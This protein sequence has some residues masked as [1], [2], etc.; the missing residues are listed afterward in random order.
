MTRDS[1][2][3]ICKRVAPKYGYDP[4]LILAQVE[5]ESSYK[6]DALRLEQGFLVKYIAGMPIAAT[7]KALLST[8]FGLGQL[9]GQSLNELGFFPALDSVS[10]V[11]RLEVYLGTPEMQ[12]ETQCQWLQKKQ[13][14][15]TSHTMDDALRRYNGSADYPPLVYAR[16]NNLKGLYGNNLAEAGR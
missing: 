2:Y 14:Q 6:E 11:M 16:Y 4:L 13:A 3:E 8:S 12:V 1:V 5:Q 9:M 10:V 7:T 15:G